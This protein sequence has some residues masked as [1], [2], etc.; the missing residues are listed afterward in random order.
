MIQ[1]INR[2]LLSFI[3]LS[4]IGCGGGGSSDAPVGIS[5][6]T[7]S[8]SLI[9]TAT[10]PFRISGLQINGTLPAGVSVTTGDAADP[11]SITAGLVVGSA[12]GTVAD[13][14][15]SVFGS[16]S[17]PNRVRLMIV[18]GSNTKPGFGPGEMVRL[19]CSVA[20]GTTISESERLALESAITFKA[21]GW[22][23]A[24]T[25]GTNPKSLNM[26]L[27]PKIAITY[28]N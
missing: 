3:L 19:T 1:N 27:Y 17:T 24:A 11:R 10:L 5:K 22:D 25:S 7:I 9:S 21:S 8:F 16:Y 23:P 26:L 13:W 6:A 12:V 20:A 15:S 14:Q 28:S 4:C 18:D 2:L